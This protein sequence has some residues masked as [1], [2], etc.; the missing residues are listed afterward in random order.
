MTSFVTHLLE[1]S[2]ESHQEP[3][4]AIVRSPKPE[5]PKME[6][7]LSSNL[8][9]EFIQDFTLESPSTRN[10]SLSHET[11]INQRLNLKLKPT[12]S[13]D[14]STF[15]FKNPFYENEGLVE[16]DVPSRS[17]NPFEKENWLNIQ[18]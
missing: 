15:K 8:I 14:I 18:Q 11:I 12:R 6:I 3:H 10:R 17:S 4:K 1:H 13:E 2:P 7:K 9:Q 16:R 5:K